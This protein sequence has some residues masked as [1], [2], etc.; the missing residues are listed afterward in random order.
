MSIFGKIASAAGDTWI[1]WKAV[2]VPWPWP[3]IVI[4]LAHGEFNWSDYRNFTRLLQPGDV[5]ITRSVPFFISNKAIPGSFK[6]GAVYTGHVAGNLDSRKHL[7]EKPIYLGVDNNHTGRPK[8]HIFERTVCHAISEGVVCQDVGELLFHADYAM[9][10]RPW[11]TIEQQQKIVHAAVRSVG[12]P[13][14]FGF[15]AK[16]ID[17][18]YCTE[19]ASYCIEEAGIP[20]PPT[21]PL[22]V[23]LFSPKIECVVADSFIKYPVVACSESCL[24]RDFQEK[25]NLGGVMRA[26]VLDAWDLSQK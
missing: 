10:V 15:D 11:E 9:V 16:N 24:D 2:N 25:S 5:I 4:G 19:L 3:S 1:N 21:T 20:P 22:R 12:K 13:Y 17:S 8:R 6:H 23:K 18:I 7:I 26:A 14:D